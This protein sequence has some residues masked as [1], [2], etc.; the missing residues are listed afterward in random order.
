MESCICYGAIGKIAGCF[1]QI[2]M[3]LDLYLHAL[4]TYMEICKLYSSH[5]TDYIISRVTSAIVPLYRHPFQ[6]R[7]PVTR[8]VISNNAFGPYSSAHH[9][10]TNRR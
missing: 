2:L 7:A 3:N 4:N 5:H 10:F 9:M 8:Y 6:P 1:S